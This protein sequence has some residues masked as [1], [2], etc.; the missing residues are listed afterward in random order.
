[1]K[2]ILTTLLLALAVGT[3][4]YYIG[5]GQKETLAPI[6]CKAGEA[7]KQAYVCPMHPHIVQG[8]A[9]TCPICGMDLVVAGGVGN[10]STQI[11]VETATQHKLGV[12]LARAERATMTHDIRTHATMVPD[13]GAVLRITPNV[14]GVLSKLHVDRVGQRVA[15][16]QVLYEISSPEV[17]PLQYEYI[18]ILRRGASAIKM[19]EDRR[20]QNAKAILDASEQEPLLREQVARGVRQSE[21]QLESILQPLRRDRERMTLRLRQIGFTDDMLARL[22]RDRQALIT[23]P[24]R[25]QRAC[26]VQEVLARSGMQIGHDTEVLSCVDTSRAWLEIALYPDQLSWVREGD[27][28]TVELEG[29]APIKSKLSGINP[30]LDHATRTARARLPIV[31]ERAANLGEY[32]AVT[33]HAAPRQMLSVPK[34]AVIRTGRGNIVMRAMGHG[35]FMPVEVSL[36][37]ESADRIAIRDGL[38]EGDEVV[39][40]GQFLLD[41][42][43]SIADAAQRLKRH[44]GE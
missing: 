32:A 6:P 2:Q 21:E 14:D 5:L 4:G 17:L 15:A 24:A 3:V 36:G 41:A 31:F 27:A 8:H 12:R 34:S 37:I 10:L 13:E 30:V 9:G 43:A 20:A 7:T 35:H 25:A 39:V 11:H 26:V 38:L 28:I 16:G 44:G 18:D 23:V 19:T 29:S 33:I 1:M 40:N 42:A 22:E